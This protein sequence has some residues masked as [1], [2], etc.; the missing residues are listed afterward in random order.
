MCL[1]ISIS[2]T[3]QSTF[4][5]ARYWLAERVCS[6]CPCSHARLPWAEQCR[7]LSWVM[8]IFGKALSAH[9]YCKAL[10]YYLACRRIP[11]RSVHPV[12]GH[13]KDLLVAFTEF[14][15]Q[16][17]APESL[18]CWAHCMVIWHSSHRGQGA[19]KERKTKP[20]VISKERSKPDVRLQPYMDHL[21]SL[22]TLV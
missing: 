10:V 2:I 1:N 8:Q 11:S 19:P 6:P 22:L 5:Q 13:V 18:L 21:R 16:R 7:V 14:A 4:W 9:A 17:L 12:D 20:V 15:A 3:S